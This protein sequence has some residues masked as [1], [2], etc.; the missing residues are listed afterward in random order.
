MRG[1]ALWGLALAGVGLHHHQADGRKREMPQLAWSKPKWR[2]FLKPSGK[3]C[4]RNRRSNSVTSSGAVRGRALPTFREVKVTV[5]SLRE[6]MRL[7]EMTPRKTYGA[8][9]VKAEWPW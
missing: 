3:T 2:T 8:R 5:R 1:L 7:L 9:E 4:W 6:T